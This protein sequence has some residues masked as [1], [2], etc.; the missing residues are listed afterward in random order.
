QTVPDTH[1]PGKWQRV[2]DHGGNPKTRHT[3][4]KIIGSRRWKRAMQFT[5]RQRREQTKRV[6][7]TAMVRHD[8]KRAIGPK[9]SVSDNFKAIVDAQQSANDQR[10]DR[11]QFIHEHVGLPWKLSEPV[12]RCAFEIARGIVTPLLHRSG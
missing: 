8:N 11:S 5:Q 2:H 9:I 3:L 6:Q 7:M 10:Y 1:L 4:E 12:E